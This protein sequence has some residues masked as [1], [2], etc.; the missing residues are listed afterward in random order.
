MA[1]DRE[2][3]D[4]DRKDLKSLF[5]SEFD[6]SRAEHWLSMGEAE[7]ANFIRRDRETWGPVIKRL[8]FTPQ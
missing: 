3:R 4:A 5:Y 1:S 2:R 8:G 7:L 6:S